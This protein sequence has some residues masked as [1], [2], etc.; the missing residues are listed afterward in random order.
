MPHLTHQVCERLY[1]R[2]YER[3]ASPGRRR[4]SAS[5]TGTSSPAAPASTTRPGPVSRPWSGGTPGRRT[6]CAVRR[7]ARRGPGRRPHGPGVRRRRSRPGPLGALDPARRPA[8]HAHP[9]RRFP[10]QVEGRRT[11]RAAAHGGIGLHVLLAPAGEDG[12]RPG[13]SASFFL[14]RRHRVRAAG[15]G[16]APDRR[17]SRRAQR[18]GDRPPPAAGLRGR[19]GRSCSPR[20]TSRTRTCPRR[21]PNRPFCAGR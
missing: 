15:P 1:E 7:R 2:G 11:G 16:P 4:A 5:C 13:W 20:P 12:A 9:V 10:R 18:E 21:R 8:R 14:H 6:G 19:S 17:R 3:A